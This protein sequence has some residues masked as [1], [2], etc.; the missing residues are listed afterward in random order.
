MQWNRGEITIRET[1][2]LIRAYHWKKSFWN[3][4]YL[5]LIKLWGFKYI[6]IDTYKE[7]WIKIKIKTGARLCI[8]PY[9]YSSEG[10][11]C[12]NGGMTPHHRE[13]YLW[14]WQKTPVGYKYL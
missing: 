3:G 12:P 14:S 10:C 1:L 9:C 13:K 7:V 6:I 4:H 2:S 8:C 11:I 5:Y